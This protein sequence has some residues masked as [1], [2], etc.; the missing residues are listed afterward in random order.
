LLAETGD[1]G[2]DT[3]RRAVRNIKQRTILEDGA[4]SGRT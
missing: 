1:F 3:V 4:C 2:G